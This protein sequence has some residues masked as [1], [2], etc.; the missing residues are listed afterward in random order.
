M[1][2]SLFATYSAGENRVTATVLAV[3][4]SLSLDRIERLLGAL[5]E[6]AEFELVRFENQAGRGGVGVPDAELLSSCRILIE[7]K[8]KPNTIDRKQLTRHLQRLDDTNEAVQRL[9]V[10]TPDESKPTELVDFSDE[11]LCW[12]SFAALDQAID[13]L[14]D[15]KTEVTSDREEFLLRE[16]QAMLL[17]E[18]LL[19]FEKDTVIV[20]ARYAWDEYTKHQLY[21]CQPGRAFQPV[22][23]VGFY[24]A[25]QILRLVPR[26]LERHD[27]VRM[28][29]GAYKGELGRAVDRLLDLALRTPGVEYQV[30]LLSGPDDPQTTRL[31]EPIENDLLSANGRR[32]AFAQGQRYVRLDNLRRAKRTS[33]LASADAKTHT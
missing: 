1:P 32:T 29:R 26:I 23:Y 30:F 31:D 11:R 27:H 21:V 10:L 25:N 9:L 7:T 12:T 13:E 8:I 22:Q 24:K 2:I 18:G 19:G 15:D 28:E 17:Q 16:L 5:T 14:L 6:Q 3:L 20:A 4:R 33:D